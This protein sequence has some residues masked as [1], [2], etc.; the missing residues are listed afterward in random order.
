MKQPLINPNINLIPKR[1]RN[2]TQKL[3]FLL[4]TLLC[5][6]GMYVRAEELTVADGTYSSN[7]YVPVY[8]SW[9][10][11]PQH[12]QCIYPEEML[13][14]MVGGSIS[15][16]KFYIASAST[17]TSWRTGLGSFN[18]GLAMTA[19]SSL[20]SSWASD[21][22]TIVYSGALD[23]SGTEMLITFATPFVYEGGNLLLDVQLP[24]AT[25]FES[26]SFYSVEKSNASRY[27]YGSSC[28]GSSYGYLPK[29]TFTYEPGAGVC[30]RP[31]N[32]QV[33]NEGFDYTFS[34]EAGG[35]ETQWQ[36]LCIPAS[37]T[38][39][40][41][42]VEPVSEL[43][44]SAAGLTPNTA[45]KFYVRS[46][47]GEGEGMQSGAVS[48]SFRTEC[49]AVSAFPWNYGFEED[50]LYC[51]IVGNAQ[52]ASTSYIPALN[53]SAAKD[54]SKGLQLYAYKSS[55]TNADSS[56][57]ILPEMN[58]LDG[59]VQRHPLLFHAKN[60][61]TS[62]S[63]YD[64]LLIGVVSDK[65][66]IHTFELVKKVG[67]TGSWD[68][69]EVSFAGFDGQEPSYSYIAIMAVVNPSASGDRNGRIY[70][71]NLGV[72]TCASATGLQVADI[73]SS[74]AKLRWDKAEGGE[75]YVICVRE[76][77]EPDWDGEEL[78]GDGYADFSEDYDQA[79]AEGLEPNTNYV[80][81][82][83]M[84]CGDAGESLVRSVAFR[85]E[86]SVIASLPWTDSFEDAQTGGYV[87]PYCW[88]RIG[89]VSGSS[90][91]PYAYN[92]SY[93]AFDGSKSLY[94][95]GGVTGTSEQVAILPALDESIAINSLQLSFMYK[96]ASISANYGHLEVGTLHYSE[97]DTVFTAVAALDKVAD[98]TL[99]EVLLTGAPADADAIAIRFI[100][101]TGSGTSAYVD[102]VV[103]A[104][105]PACPALKALRVS[106]VQ[107]R[108]ISVELSPK[109]GVAVGNSQLLIVDPASLSLSAP[110]DLTD[111]QLE[112]YASNFVLL[113]GETS[114]TFDHLD[115][116]TTYYIY[117]RAYCEGEAATP[118]LSVEAKTLDLLECG[119]K[120]P[121]GV[122]TALTSLIN[123]SWGCTY[124]Q[125]IYTAAELQALGYQAGT[126][127]S[128]SFYYNSSSSYLSKTQSVYI[129]T[130]DS[131]TF[132][133]YT[134][135]DF[136]GGLTLVYG[137]TLNTFQSGW[138]TYEFST[139]FVWDGVSNIVIGLLTNSATSSSSNWGTYGTSS[140]DVRTIYRYRD[141]TPIDITDLSAVSNGSSSSVLPN[142]KF[143]LC[144]AGNPCPAVAEASFERI[145]EGTTKVAIHW[146]AAEGD[147]LSGYEVFVSD[148]AVV[149][150]E[151]VPAEAV[152]ANESS[153]L[154]HTFEGLTPKHPYYAYVRA[155]CQA[156]AHDE[157]MSGWVE[158]AFTTLADCPAVVDLD[159]E[160]TALNVIDA[161]WSKAKAEQEETFFY[162]L[163]TEALDHE[164]I[165]AATPVEADSVG[166]HLDGLLYDQDYYI[167]VAS[168]C[169]EDV[170]DYDTVHV[171]T[172]PACQPVE[173]IAASRLQHNLIELTWASATFAV[174]DQWAVRLTDAEGN[175]VEG[176]SVVVSE[177]K[178][179]F[180]GLQPETAYKAYVQA[181]C[182]EEL[183]SAEAEFDFTTEAQPAAE[184]K[185]G[186][187]TATTSYYPSHAHYNYSL[188]EQIYTA[189]EIGRS[190]Q[191]LSLT[192]YNGGSNVVT[193]DLTIYLKATE[194]S[195]FSSNSDWEAV[196]VADLVFS[197]SVTMLAN[198]ATL[199]TLTT[200]FQ[201]DG[202]SNLVLVVDDNTANYSSTYPGYLT[203]YV[204]ST[205]QTIYYYSDGTNLDPLN[206]LT[207]SG[208]RSTSKNQIAFGFEAKAC[209][210]VTKLAVSDIKAFTA[211]LSW[212]P[213][214]SETAW[215]TIMSDTAI[216][217]FTALAAEDTVV[218]S[219]LVLNATNLTAEAEHFFYIQPVC[220][221]A[222]GWKS[223]S[224]TTIPSCLAPTS[225]AVDRQSITAHTATISWADPNEEPAGQYII[226]YGPSAS[227]DLENPETY[228]TKT[229]DAS[230]CVLT[231]LAADASFKAAV[232]A[233]CGG[234]DPSHFSNVVSFSTIESC[235][236][237]GRPAVLDSSLSTT[238]ATLYWVDSRKAEQGHYILI[239]G[240]TDSLDLDDP[241]T[242]VS[243]AVA[244]TAYVLEGLT[245][246]TS[247][248]ALVRT[249]C[250]SEGVSRNSNRLSFMTE[251][252]VVTEFPWSEN[253]EGY[254]SYPTNTRWSDNCWVNVQHTVG[255][256]TSGS[257]N[258]GF[259][260]YT[261]A[262]GG[263]ESVKLALPDMKAGEKTLLALPEMNIPEANA[264]EF[265]ISVYRNAT[266]ESYQ[267]EGVRIYVSPE[268]SV[269][270]VNA[271]ELGFI[272]RN[273]NVK[274]LDHGIDAEAESGWYTYQFTIPMSGLCHIIVLGE[275]Q[276]GSSTYMDN[277]LVRAI[278][279]CK[280]PV[281][282]IASEEDLQARSARIVWQA[283]GE[284]TRFQYVVLP[285]GEELGDEPA[286]VLVNEPAA[287]LEDLTPNTAYDIYVRAYCGE[288]LQS[289]PRMGASFR[290]ACAAVPLP[291]AYGFEEGLYCY[292]VGNMQSKSSSYIPYLSS[293]AKHDGQYG[294]YI[295]A[296][297]ST[298]T[299]GTHADSA[300]VILPEF[301][302]G[303]ED[304]IRNY[305]ISLY[306]KAT[307]TTNTY[308]AYNEHLLIGVVETPDSAGMASFVKVADVTLTTTMNQYELPLAAYQGQG[309]YIALLAVAPQSTLSSRYGSFYVDDINV[310]R[311]PACQ[312]LASVSVSN[313]ERRS[314]TV[315]LHAKNGQSLGS[316][317]ELVC[318]TAALSDE[319]LEAADKIQV[320]DTNA[321]A[322]TG[323]ERDTRY[324]IYVRA[325]CG[326]DGNSTWVSTEAK[327]KALEDCDVVTIGTGDSK[328]Y[329]FPLNNFYNYSY[330]QQ[331]FDAAEVGSEGT[332]SQVSFRYAYSTDMAQA[333][334]VSIYM[335]HTTKSEFASTSDWVPFADLTLV[336]QGALN[337]TQGWNDFVLT[338][339]FEYNGTDNLVLAV[340]DN[341]YGYDGQSYTFYYTSGTQYKSLYYYSDGSPC[342]ASS[343][344][345]GYRSQS[346][347]NVRF[348]VCAPGAPCPVVTNVQA[349]LVGAGA[350]EAKV[351]WTAPTNVD[352]LSGYELLFST[353]AVTDFDAVAPEAIKTLAIGTEEYVT[354]ELEASTDYYI[355]VRAVCMAEE[356][357]DGKS[358]WAV[359]TIATL[360]DCPAVVSLS[361]EVTGLNVAD[362]AWDV[363][364]AAQD[365]AFVYVLSDVELDDEALAAA[366]MQEVDSLGLHLT[367][368]NYE[369]DYYLYVASH[370]G[371]DISVFEMTHF[372]T[373]P[374]CQPVVNLQAQP[375]HNMVT[376]TWESAQFAE[377]TQWEAGIVGMDNTVLVSERTAQFIGL[378]AET[379]YQAFVRPV[380][381]ETLT[382]GETVLDFTTAAAPDGCIQIGTGTY[383]NNSVPFASYYHN[384]Y[385]QQLY[386]A[387]EIEQGAGTIRSIAFG[388]GATMSTTRNITVYMANTTVGTLSSYV[389]EDLVEVYSA[390]NTE[391][392]GDGMVN[393]PLDNAFD[394]TGGNLVVAVYMNYDAA[395][396]SYSSTSRF[397]TSSISGMCLY[398][399]NDAKAKDTLHIADAVPVTGKTP[400]VQSSRPNIR[401]CFEPKACLDVKNLAVSDITKHSAKVSWIPMGNES[402]WNVVIS[403]S[404]I[405]DFTG[406][407]SEEV[408]FINHVFDQLTAGIEYHVYVQ[409]VCDGA[410]WKHIS[411]ITEA[412]CL[413]VTNLA[414]EAVTESGAR[415]TWTDPNAE[416]A[417]SYT[418]AYG[419][420]ES[421]DLNDAATFAT[422]QSAN[423]FAN[424]SDLEPLTTY[425]YAV[426]ADCGTA[427]ATDPSDYS[428]VAQFTTR[429]GAI[430]TLPWSEDFED[431]T[432]QTIP[433][434]WDNSASASP[435]AS[436]SNSWYV[437]GVY[438]KNDNQML[439]MYNWYVS[440]GTALINTPLI[441]LPNAECEF[442]FNYANQ[443]NCGAFEVRISVDGG[444]FTSLKSYAE[445]GSTDKEVVGTWLPDTIA[446]ADYAGHMIQLQFFAT[447]N[448]SSGSIFVDNVRVALVGDDTT[449]GLN[450]Y[451]ADKEQAVK[452]IIDGKLFILRNG[453]WYD[454]TGRRIEEPLR[455]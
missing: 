361:N 453:L 180:I 104:A 346:R 335:G 7:S 189:E 433:Q 402:A 429:C 9:T 253:F 64:S 443:A 283:G 202:T 186:E 72:G 147:Y 392:S 258:L 319:Q 220:E 371:E 300:Y 239:Y 324:Y 3:A 399:V 275:S 271:Q 327:T 330:T 4:I 403:E 95:Y 216:V 61:S 241:E 364:N 357:N 128:V 244:D 90:T 434:C 345:A 177:R 259:R 352:Y 173:N 154:S 45:Y 157:G 49:A 221:G 51:F 293:S 380:C 306:A 388:Y 225:A 267:Q 123:T 208:S 84:N 235:F 406:V 112:G 378:E 268:A 185:I 421:F 448:Y 182:G 386:T 75:P 169:G 11:N 188:T 294:L 363:V 289:E 411:F 287:E 316:N 303:D 38:P 226:A 391:F 264:Y 69:Y 435:T 377:E 238:G 301:E 14:D 98:Y 96:Q 17:K 222:E 204:G 63:Y 121:T 338:T 194:K 374:E 227:F 142:A 347:N 146:S 52:S 190:G 85:T 395:E 431:L 383:L 257:S 134:A 56:Y 353:E 219:Q 243:V 209:S 50:Q 237:A 248:T 424:L 178:A 166:V 277:F 76:G 29:A 417:G 307:S 376:L 337:C 412:S 276:Y 398:E 187:G 24:Q 343:P 206:S 200:P 393:L 115:R 139:P 372:T 302:L 455:K 12:T 339:P 450:A 246:N 382:G 86:C 369:Q 171:K 218:V 444:E 197:G 422:V 325:N 329:Y 100:G 397:Y 62:T 140:T 214:G 311:T 273:I 313:I 71:D 299:Y 130:T 181:V 82:I 184:A 350:H 451:S 295:S 427:D 266:G 290:T 263:N 359:A 41:E 217:D 162:I 196:S 183:S 385:S 223:I 284:E 308:S 141:N 155:V 387:A 234:S 201:Y 414:A 291:Y 446:L 282:I 25:I 396:T 144:V 97:S 255:T 215:R 326:E 322:L 296:S 23:A 251:C 1:M 80:F 437:W 440:E 88:E 269:D 191:I 54:G 103:L 280:E 120:D 354:N 262:M 288:D 107:R 26:A 89:Y 126:I 366:T 148:T 405:S 210:D 286:W 10:D 91:Y 454:A 143:G 356:H 358:D 68:F 249:D 44:A 27:C 168:K 379:D 122:G 117:A 381:S 408:D 321:Y 59:S 305:S 8:G 125:T 203:Y 81:Y 152:I 48:T 92:Y 22:L 132:S 213:M 375:A 285:Q 260:I 33:S 360:A 114:H 452:L 334:E 30:R 342:P 66:D 145:E 192:F 174:E 79:M 441:Q 109:D 409:P 332:I 110:S 318:A 165:E 341:L 31:V 373:L 65:D 410:D 250:G 127:N 137:P 281:G 172:L 418:V 5:C 124:S 150:F 131:A 389:T 428:A 278:P 67:V 368:L 32:L 261:S 20:S 198:G 19:Q 16:L 304:A 2:F 432:A 28:S 78:A 46:Y 340:N 176:A 149:D 309:K 442:T 57:V 256:G 331:I 297:Y 348:S 161:H 252:E 153:A 416:P 135:D 384:S 315:T 179:L 39:N 240:I 205:N 317:Y 407:A 151:A 236:A 355:Y 167:Y 233:N 351:S 21:E 439:R 118:W 365:T 43:S 164:G 272:S 247:Y 53:T 74:S 58:F 445:S 211:K 34:W 362:I 77:E 129:G 426:M 116:N 279:D 6:S 55:Y 401:F 37:E 447:A 328:G 175:A 99:A 245:P 394:Y 228:L 70:I 73:T 344:I 430:T 390:K 18:V 158:V 230:P 425:S 265:F 212:E 420:A 404:E 419:P 159:A 314:M 323:L 195:S 138:R 449:T 207:A 349:E 310:F 193:R 60:Y 336:Y 102:S 370:C 47:C 199:I 232:M 270:N 111:E 108:S 423:L 160:L 231:E 320:V 292:T 367:G 436:G 133:G 298:G 105:A 106:D 136:I 35:E 312:P 15:S 87:M 242:Y 333:T 101:G 119:E 156:E 415:I 413:G 274:D 42:G 254:A 224:F 438:S 163:S 93:S 400:S 40:W 94:F 13:E 83:K 113:E 36:Y 170:S 229:V